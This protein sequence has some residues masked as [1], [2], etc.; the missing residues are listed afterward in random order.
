MTPACQEQKQILFF[1]AFSGTCQ[2]MCDV[3]NSD[4]KVPTYL[5]RGLFVGQSVGRTS[6]NPQGLVLVGVHAAG[7]NP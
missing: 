4:I 7:C 6:T 1:L 5:E 2:L 3:M